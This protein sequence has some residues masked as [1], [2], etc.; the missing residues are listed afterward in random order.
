MNSTTFPLDGAPLEG[1]TTASKPRSRLTAPFSRRTGLVV[2]AALLVA[3]GGAAFIAAPKAA[4]STDAAYVQA[5]SSV[6]APRVRGLVAEV[7]AQHN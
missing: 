3:A 7:R 6:V 1:A 2:G 4:E 5:D